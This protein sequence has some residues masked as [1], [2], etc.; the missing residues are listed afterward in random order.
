[1]GQY[2]KAVKALEQAVEKVPANAAVNDH[3]G[4]V[5]YKQGRRR[6]ARFQWAHARVLPEDTSPDLIKKIENKL[7]G[8][9]LP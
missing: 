4:D 7:A 9:Q 2:D 5:Y 6:E 8:K 1:M 3:L